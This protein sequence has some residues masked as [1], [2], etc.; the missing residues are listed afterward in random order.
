M[1]KSISIVRVH[2]W[3]YHYSQTEYINLNHVRQIKGDGRNRYTENI[4]QNNNFL[5]TQLTT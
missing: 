5:L 1:A 4:V 3:V 2:S